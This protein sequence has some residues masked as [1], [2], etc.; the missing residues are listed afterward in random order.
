MRKAF[1]LVEILIVAAILGILAAVVVPTLQGHIALATE[2]SAKDNL[3]L[4]RNAIEHYAIEHND[5]A[6]GYPDGDTTSPLIEEGFFGQLC[7]ITNAQG[8]M[9][10]RHF[11]G[12]DYG[13]YLSKLPKNPF[14]Q[15]NT[16]EMVESLPEEAT[17]LTGWVYNA[18]TKEIRL[19]WPGTD[20]EGKQYYDY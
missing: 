2:A 4:L 13:P 8:Q 14:N 15:Q 11:P 18:A 3:R 16:T 17:G 6:P 20:T 12:Y 1:S 5:V 7:G 9:A 10:P 19:N